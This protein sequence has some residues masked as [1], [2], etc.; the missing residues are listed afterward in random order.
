MKA[1]GL[2]GT[3]NSFTVTFTPAMRRRLHRERLVP[4]SDFMPEWMFQAELRKRI[5]SGEVSELDLE[6]EEL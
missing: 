4:N 1:R 3:D 2:T 6:M 5:A